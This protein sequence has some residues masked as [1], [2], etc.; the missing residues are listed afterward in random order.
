M[1]L[2]TQSRDTRVPLSAFSADFRVLV[3]DIESAYKLGHRDSVDVQVRPYDDFVAWAQAQDPDW[4]RYAWDGTKVLVEQ[5]RLPRS[6]LSDYDRPDLRRADATADEWHRL[7]FEHSID[8]IARSIAAR[9]N[10]PPL[11]AV[12]GKPIDG[13]HRAIAAQQLG[14]FE[15]PVIDLCPVQKSARQLDAEIS[16]ALWSPSRRGTR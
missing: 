5:G 13:R 4:D 11:V 3:S 15:A 8:A 16:E 2:W 10:V 1:N 7:G 6:A 14:L 9:K 12:C